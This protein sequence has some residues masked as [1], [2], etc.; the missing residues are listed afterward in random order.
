MK[1]RIPTFLLDKPSSFKGEVQRGGLS[2]SFLDKAIEHLSEFIRTTYIQW[3]L[4]S[5]NGLFQRLDARIKILFLILFVVEVSLKKNI[6]AE[7]AIGAFL[8]VLVVAS[9]LPLLGFYWR[10]FILG[11]LFGFLIP[12]PSVLN[13]F[14]PGELI[15]PLVR[16]S[17]SYTIWLYHLPEVVGI[18]RE[19]LS[20]VLMLASRVINSLSITFLVLYTTAFPEIIRALRV[21]RLPETALLVITLTNKYVFLFVNTVQDMYRARKARSIG[22]ERS[23][24]TRSWVASRI[25]LMFKRSQIRFEDVYK[26][27]NSRGFSGMVKSTDFRRFRAFDGFIGGLLFGAGILF[28]II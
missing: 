7:V 27:M 6:L 14:T 11:G 8:L 5:R 18:T 28:L 26:A 3:D 12:L 4:A 25:A 22:V 13:L 19:G 23:A 16:F 17:Q 2:T 15:F 20:G 9:R 24:E 21:F 1:D 10:I